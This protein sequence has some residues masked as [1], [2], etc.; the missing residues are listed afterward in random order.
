[1]IWVVSSVFILLEGLLHVKALCLS[2]LSVG[3]FGLCYL[4]GV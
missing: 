3:D 1:M 2:N 4:L